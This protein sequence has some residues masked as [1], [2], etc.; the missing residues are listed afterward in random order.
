[1][2]EA[3][4]SEEQTLLTIT[5]SLFGTCDELLQHFYAYSR[6]ETKQGDFEKEEQFKATLEQKE[7][8]LK[9]LG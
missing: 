6:C 7:Q 5:E 1:M 9:A 4:I 3:V 8:E 2:L